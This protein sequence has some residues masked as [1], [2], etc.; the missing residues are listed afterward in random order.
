MEK[1]LTASTLEESSLNA[2]VIKEVL[3]TIMVQSAFPVCFGL[4][5][6]SGNLF[7]L[8]WV[9]YV[10]FPVLDLILP[11]DYFNPSPKQVRAL[12]KDS[13][14]LIPLYITFIQDWLILFYACHL[15]KTNPAY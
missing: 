14:F 6:Y 13:R 12:E 1:S 9:L 15:I 5:I 11:K 10:L 7:I 3:F 2:Y 4:S 8:L